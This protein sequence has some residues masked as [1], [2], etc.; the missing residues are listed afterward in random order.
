ARDKEETNKKEL[1]ESNKHFL[2]PYN[3][4]SPCQNILREFGDFLGPQQIK[5]LLL[6]A[7]EGLKGSSEA[8]GKD[9]REM[10]Q[11][12]SEVTLSSVLEWYRHRAL[13]VV[14][15]PGGRD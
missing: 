15:P 3:P 2:G 11:L 5:D 6:A 10:M 9:S 14:R 8:P 4:V 1:Y 7:L 12:A 13:E